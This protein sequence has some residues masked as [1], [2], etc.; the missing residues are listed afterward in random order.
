MRP[1]IS[2]NGGANRAERKAEATAVKRFRRSDAEGSRGLPQI[3]LL[4]AFLA[5]PA[6]PAFSLSSSSVTSSSSFL[7]L[8]SPHRVPAERDGGGPVCAVTSCTRSDEDTALAS[9]SGRGGGRAYPVGDDG[10][11]GAIKIGASEA[12][13]ELRDKRDKERG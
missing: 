4:R 3:A 5:R 9:G 11:R 1:W 12:S 10:G 8:R 13:D 6:F 7:P 2:Q